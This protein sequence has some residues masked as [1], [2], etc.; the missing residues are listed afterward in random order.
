VLG[1]LSTN[2]LSKYQFGSSGITRNKDSKDVISLGDDLKAAASDS[3][4][5]CATLFGVGL[6]L[7]SAKSTSDSESKKPLQGGQE[8]PENGNGRVSAKQHQYIISLGQ[9]RGMSKKALND[10][11][12]ATYGVGLDFLTRKDAS[13]LI[14]SMRTETK[15]S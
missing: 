9:H 15:G 8:T 11:C 10:H 14:E 4:K 5:K 6:H 13:F 1:K 2:G 12:I 3:L 7:Y